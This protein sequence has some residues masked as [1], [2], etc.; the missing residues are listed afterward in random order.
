MPTTMEFRPCRCGSGRSWQQCC[1]GMR[2]R[3]DG[4]E[5][6]ACRNEL[7]V[8]EEHD[9]VDCACRDR[10]APCRECNAGLARG[11]PDYDVIHD[12]A[13][14]TPIRVDPLKRTH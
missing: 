8:C 7:W 1:G 2:K 3:D 10:S 5:C 14:D 11:G 13:S 4:I 9:G 12:V 6:N